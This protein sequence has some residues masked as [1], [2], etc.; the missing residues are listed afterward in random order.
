MRDDKLS[1]LES[2]ATRSSAS[3]YRPMPVLR[4]Q[5]PARQSRALR[6]FETIASQGSGGRVPPQVRI[7]VDY[8]TLSCVLSQYS[9][10]RKSRAD[11]LPSPRR[12][13]VTESLAPAKA[14]SAVDK[15]SKDLDDLASLDWHN[16][17]PDKV[18][19]RLGVATRAG[20]DNEMVA[21]R[22]ASDGKNVITPTK[23][24]WLRKIAS[25]FL[26]GFGSLL[27]R[28]DPV[29]RCLAPAR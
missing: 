29:L 6:R 2:T 12:I 27:R 5:A 3:S 7:P 21:R 24:N 26:S 11:A 19:Q 15:K 23:I 17:S 22:L 8:R 10:D 25:Y 14:T 9:L 18:A 1:D 16:L 13:Q 20:L 4:M 28:L